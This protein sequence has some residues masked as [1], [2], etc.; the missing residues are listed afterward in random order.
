VNWPGT[1]PTGKINDNLIDLSDFFVTLAELAGAELPHAV[2]LDGKSF[3]P[4][5]RGEKGSPRDWVYVELDGKSYVRDA[6]YKLTNG[7]QMFDLTDAPFKEVPVARDTSAP[8]AVAARQKLQAVL[9]AHPAAPIRRT[10]LEALKK[11]AHEGQ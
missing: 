6:R 10:D 2:T 8:S 4:Q 1:T 3:A 7:G 11:S 5:I 9:D